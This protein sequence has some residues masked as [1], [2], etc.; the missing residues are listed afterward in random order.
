VEV[1]P[2]AYIDSGQNLKHVDVSHLVYPVIPPAPNP[3]TLTKAANPTLLV[4]LATP[5]PA[6]DVT[7][8]VTINNS[9]DHAIT[10]DELRDTL[11]PGFTYTPGSATFGGSAIPDPFINAQNLAWIGSFAVPALSS[12]QLV[13]HATTPGN[14]AVGTYDNCAT[15]RINGTQIDLT[16]DTTDNAPACARV[17]VIATPPA[18][19]SIVIKKKT[20]G[21]GASFNYT[22]SPAPPLANFSIDATAG[23]GAKTFTALPAD[24][25][26][27]TETVPGGWVLTSI[28]C[29]L[30]PS[31]GGS[32]TPN[33]QTASVSITLG[34]GDIHAE[35]EFTNTRL[36]SITIAKD[37]TPQVGQAFTFNATNLPAPFVLT[38][39]GTPEQAF[40]NLA[41][42]TYSVTEL[43]PAGWALDAIE[44]SIT[45]AGSNTT[46]F[47]YAGAP[48]GNTN[49]F[50]PG[51]TTAQITLGAGDVVRCVFFDAQNGSITIV[52]QSN[53][54]DGTFPFDLDQSP[55]SAEAS[56]TTVGGTGQ[57]T[58]FASVSPGFYSIRELVPID[59][60][61][62]SVS[63][64]SSGGST[65]AYAGS[66]A[67]T[68]AFDAG[69]DTAEIDLAAG[70]AVICTFTNTLVPQVPVPTLSEG[71]LI[72][73]AMLTLAGG[74]ASLRRAGALRAQRRP[75]R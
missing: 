55:D 34:T 3:A 6:F 71:M 72:L 65:F 17:T 75:G 59:W 18:G 29:T 45:S 30:A 39:P 63:C 56:I 60:K 62:T 19:G 40:A 21:G 67:G 10:L 16:A 48:S 15:A 35:C 27:I 53:G 22:A 49:A 64:T 41:A 37:A 31:T 44:C 1:N 51:D 68:D 24:T 46:T 26:V 42:G 23:S 36:G 12:R 50:E 58:P 11:P 66:N 9:D 8:T 5:A 20:I 43:V 47:A 57:T 69:D 70:D 73:L 52:K 2:Y 14:V 4:Q 33:L 25:Y 13:F 32:W 7:F 74:A 28:A 38:P 61:L 54:G